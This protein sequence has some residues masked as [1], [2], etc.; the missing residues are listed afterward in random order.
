M[1]QV[2]AR[3]HPTGRRERALIV[4]VLP[5]LML[6]MLLGALDQTIMAPALP[7]V[8]G[9]LGGLA[10]IPAVVTAY[11]AAATVVMPAYGKLG[12]R[13]GRPRVLL[14][15]IGIFM[16]GAV[17][18]AI[19]QSMAVLVLA[20]VIQGAGGGGLMIGAQAVL[21]EVVSP[22]ER[23][24][25]LGLLSSVFILAAVGGPLLGGLIVD[26]LS[27]RWIFAGYLPLGLL[28]LI[29]V[30]RTLRLPLP[31][32]RPPIDYVGAI[33]LAIAVLSV[34]LLPSIVG[35]VGQAPVW[36]MPALIIVAVAAT[37]AW[38]LTAR[39]AADPILPLRLFRDRSFAIPTAISFLIGF[40]LFGTVSYLP[41]YLQ[42]ATGASSTRAGLVVTCLMAG[43]I[44]TLIISGQLISRTG[45]Y[46]IFPIMGTALAAG[47]LALLATVDPAT[48]TP[49][50]LAF[51]LLIGFGVGL[52]MQ[53]MMLVAQNG[54]PRGDLGTATSTVTFLRQIGASAGVAVIGAMITLRF[55]EGLPEVVLDRL[56]GGA[57]GLST[58]RLQALPADVQA[59]VAAAYGAAVP[60]VFGYVAP[61][62]GV[63]FVLALAL[64][65]RPLRDT[66]YADEPAAEPGTHQKG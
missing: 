21:G 27:W 29:I 20:R 22:R 28:A 41:S 14:V 8:A 11:L 2:S 55:L 9:D 56:P 4:R 32:A 10:Q 44:I 38:L 62:L 58:D 33:L 40:A 45:R 65:A 47:G 5:G 39:R 59:A 6:V 53:V 35:R 30:R 1:A 3:R 16:A 63:A 24:R 18:C 13:F 37:A 12:D 52:T 46:R 36:A 23:G 61:L 25:Y 66:A 60:P 19:A 7:A 49:V 42:I 48:P 15:A 57:G 64:P 51:L 43:V 26:H 34:V 54:V 31:Q 17:L 50:M